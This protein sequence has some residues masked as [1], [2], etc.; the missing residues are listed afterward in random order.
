MTNIEYFKLQAND[1][2]I[3]TGGLPGLLNEKLTNFLKLETIK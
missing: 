3:I 1:R 2:I